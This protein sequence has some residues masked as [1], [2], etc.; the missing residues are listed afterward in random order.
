MEEEDYDDDDDEIRNH[1]LKALDEGQ[2]E[3]KYSKQCEKILRL[4][5][6]WNNTDGAQAIL[7]SIKVRRLSPS[8]IEI[9]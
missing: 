8:V 5:V 4:A 2:L 9:F 1:Y 3:N 7:E 6:S